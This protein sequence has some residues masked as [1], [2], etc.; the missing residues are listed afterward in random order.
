MPLLPE[1]FE[2]R[3]R[4]DRVMERLEDEISSKPNSPQSERVSGRTTESVVLYYG[5]S[6]HSLPDNPARKADRCGASLVLRFLFRAS[7]VVRR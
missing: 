6:C 4:L 7:R 2:V 3:R 1:E 5:G